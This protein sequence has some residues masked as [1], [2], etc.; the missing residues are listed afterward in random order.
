MAVRLLEGNEAVFWERTSHPLLFNRL[1]F[2][3]NKDK[4]MPFVRNSNKWL[5]PGYNL[6][7]FIS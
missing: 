4:L 2:G 5:E 7:L 1:T 6:L 3:C